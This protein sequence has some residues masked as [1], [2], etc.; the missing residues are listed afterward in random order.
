ML[1]LCFRSSFPFLSHFPSHLVP[2][3]LTLYHVIFRPF[4]TCMIIPPPYIVAEV[5][6]FGYS[7]AVFFYSFLFFYIFIF[8]SFIFLC[9]PSAPFFTEI[10]F[11]F[12]WVDVFPYLMSFFFSFL[13][14]CIYGITTGYYVLVVSLLSFFP[15][16]L[17]PSFLFLC[18]IFPA[19]SF[20]CGF[21]GVLQFCFFPGSNK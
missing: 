10:W 20:Q 14:R 19:P 11:F 2:C 15:P 4:V 18:H 17:L 9:S 7:Y 13:S 16:N 6:R 21:A 12:H 3:T 5:T 1:A 8:T